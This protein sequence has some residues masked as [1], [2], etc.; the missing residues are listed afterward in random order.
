MEVS[1]RALAASPSST[2]HSGAGLRSLTIKEQ[3][4]PFDQEMTRQTL[5]TMILN[6]LS[7]SD[8]LVKVVKQSKIQFG[9]KFTNS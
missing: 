7:L 8:L 9:V 3:R 6:L 1:S 2:L 5:R 4:P